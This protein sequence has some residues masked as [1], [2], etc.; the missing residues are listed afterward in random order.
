PVLMCG[1]AEF[2]EQVPAVQMLR[3]VM[4]RNLAGIVGDDSSGV[5]DDALGLRFLPIIA[6]PANVVTNRIYLR[7]VSLSPAGDP[8]IPRHVQ[9]QILFPLVSVAGCV[10]TL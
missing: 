3:W 2:A 10:C 7:D 9:G 4:K 8:S 6:P 5:N 1:T